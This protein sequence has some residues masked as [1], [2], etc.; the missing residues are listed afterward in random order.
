MIILSHSYI[1]SLLC[2]AVYMKTLTCTHKCVR[3]CVYTDLG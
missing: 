3:V 1:T 2:A